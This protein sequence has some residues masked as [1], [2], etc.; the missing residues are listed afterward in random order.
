MRV[1]AGDAG[2]TWGGLYDHHNNDNKNNNTN[3]NNH[4]N[5]TE[6]DQA[7]DLGPGSP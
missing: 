2:R 4:N 5:K 1:A 3:N 7:D 6:G